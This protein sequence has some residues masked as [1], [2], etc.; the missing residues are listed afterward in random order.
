[1]LCHVCICNNHTHIQ[2]IPFFCVS[3]PTS[4]SMLLKT[5]DNLPK[6]ILV[7]WVLDYKTKLS[8]TLIIAIQ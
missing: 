4:L 1:M 2:Y 6:I 5:I 7:Y 8:T 3:Y